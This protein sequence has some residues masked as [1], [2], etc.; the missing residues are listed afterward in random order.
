MYISEK[1]LEEEKK[2]RFCE[3][4]KGRVD[5]VGIRWYYTAY[6]NT[7]KLFPVQNCADNEGFESGNSCHL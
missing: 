3:L 6:C 2:L 5:V 1:L 4:Q 7:I